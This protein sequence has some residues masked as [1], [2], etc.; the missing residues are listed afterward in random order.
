M[1]TSLHAQSPEANLKI[2][3]ADSLFAQKM[4]TQSFEIY[5]AIFDQK[6]YSQAMLLKMAFI[7]E[8]L[9]HLSQSMYY[10]NLYYL[11]SDDEQ[12][13]VKMEKVASENRLSGYEG[14]QMDLS[15][16][17]QENF[18]SISQVLM[19]L[20]VFFFSLMIY[21]KRI[22]DKRPYILGISA[23]VT[24]GLLFLHINFSD[25][26]SKGIVANDATYVMSGPSAG[27][28]VLSIINEGHQLEILD[29][30]DV[31]LKVKWREGEAYIK[32]DQLLKIEL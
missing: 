20:T 18:V 31:W 6:M 10:L 26:L 27:S 32:D 22:S 19:G 2:K 23:L 15:H 4:Y 16:M 7:Q 29:R 21:Q 17:L 5:K 9:G 1:L 30:K 14:N 3:D 11:A 24:I 28:S 12:A 13:L 8:G 25:T